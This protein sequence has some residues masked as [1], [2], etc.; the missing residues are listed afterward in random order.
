MLFILSLK[1]IVIIFVFFRGGVELKM[2]KAILQHRRERLSPNDIDG[3][4]RLD[5]NFDNDTDCKCPNGEIS[6]NIGL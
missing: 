5:Y 2:W 3:D 6:D 4:A 1:F